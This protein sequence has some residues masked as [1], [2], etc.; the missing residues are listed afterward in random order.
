MLNIDMN[1]SLI[2]Y[3]TDRKY[4]ERTITDAL[5]KTGLLEIIV[6]NDTGKDFQLNN[7]KVIT[8]SKAGPAKAW[9]AASTE[10]L[11]DILV[12][13]KDKTKFG[14]DWLLPIVEKLENKNN[15]LV[16][17]VVYTL[18]LDLW[19]T[20]STR[21]RRFGWRWDLGLY[22]RQCPNN[23]SESPAISSYCIACKKEWFCEIGE[24]DNVGVGGGEDIEL[25]IRSWLCGGTVEVCDDSH[26][27]VALEINYSNNTINNL[28]RIAENWFP[29]KASNFY[30]SRQI[31]PKS[32]NC[33]R[34]KSRTTHRSMD[35]FFQ[36]IQ[37]E[38]AGA[39]DLN[40]YAYGKSIAIVG[41]GPSLDYVNL[42]AVNRHDIV[43][44]VDYV[45]EFIDCDFV[46]TNSTHIISALK[47]K[48]SEEQFILPL[49]LDDKMS[50]ETIYAIDIM[51]SA[52]QFD[53][54]S[55]GTPPLSIDPPFC[56]FD[57]L[58][59]TA[60]HIALF[61][62]PSDITL[63]GCDN[64]IINDCSHTT[65]IDHYNNGKLWDDS[66]GLRRQFAFYEFGLDQLGKLA[67][68]SKIPLLRVNHA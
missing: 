15:C 56:N 61:M 8:T 44:G 49:V 63:F 57:N 21:W 54:N 19:Q 48:Y 2:I 10:A 50:G 29:E 1:V 32:V 20:E 26:V 51:P 37:P 39:Y 52:K 64:K 22:D 67:V 33:G 53:L 3:S 66:D 62:S 23:K 12:F 16:S 34:L 28:A 35:W 6:C 60:A 58:A 17:P 25:S 7:A 40:G 38:L 4:L 59:I 43:I 36:H 13:V 11:G 45:G 41:A 18:D 68:A 46:I 42:A 55:S 65:R 27:S 5:D 31:D 24:F 30:K 47:S 14:V 9:N